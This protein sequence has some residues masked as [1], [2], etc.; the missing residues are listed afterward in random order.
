MKSSQ[1]VENRKF[2]SFE[3]NESRFAWHYSAESMLEIR[4]ILIWPVLY[5][6]PAF[7]LL[8]EIE[9]TLWTLWDCRLDSF[10]FEKDEIH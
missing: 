4:S 2:E 5:D 6:R 7:A 1:I 9:S 10:P 3:Q 8:R